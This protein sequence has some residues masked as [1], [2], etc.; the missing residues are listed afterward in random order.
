MPS[1]ARVVIKCAS[2]AAHCALCQVWTSRSSGPARPA[3][4]YLEA[5]PFPGDRPRRSVRP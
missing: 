2:A 4:R 5:A 3:R 1:C